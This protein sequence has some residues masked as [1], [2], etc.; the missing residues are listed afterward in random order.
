MM[1]VTVENVKQ[2]VG[3]GGSDKKELIK[4]GEVGE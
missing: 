1:A 2:A 4:W 3:G